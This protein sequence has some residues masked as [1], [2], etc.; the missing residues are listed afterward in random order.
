MPH[1]LRTGL[2]IFS[3]ISLASIGRSH[4]GHNV[5]GP[6][7]PVRALKSS[8]GISRFGCRFALDGCASSDEGSGPQAKLSEPFPWAGADWQLVVFPN[9]YGPAQ[10]HASAYLRLVD[11]GRPRP[12][13]RGLSFAITATA[14]RGAV[15]ARRVC[16]AHVF[17][18]VWASFSPVFTP[19]ETF[20]NGNR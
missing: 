2:L 4:T 17:S 12:L 15:V 20:S 6:Y 8:D 5:N 13:P 10:G 19:L 14:A 3:V 18:T 9:G 11:D 7:Y 16:A 1:G